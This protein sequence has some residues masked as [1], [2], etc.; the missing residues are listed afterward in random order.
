MAYNIMSRQ[1]WKLTERWYDLE[2]AK[3]I[4]YTQQL[5]NGNIIPGTWQLT[6]QWQEYSWMHP[7][8]RAKYRKQKYAQ[9]RKL[10][11]QQNK[12]LNWALK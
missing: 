7:N 5:R 8:D 12:I 1:V 9:N 11:R 4:A 2:D 10:K 3:R 6:E